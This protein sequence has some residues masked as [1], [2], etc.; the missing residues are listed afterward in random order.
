MVHKPKHFARG[1]FLAVKILQVCIAL[2]ALFVW[3]VLPWK[4]FNS[5]EF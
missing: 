2:N 5:K 1:E 3:K 4:Y